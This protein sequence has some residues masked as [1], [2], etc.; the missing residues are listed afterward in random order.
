MGNE[1]RKVNLKLNENSGTLVAPHDYELDATIEYVVD[2]QGEMESQ[3][4]IM[5]AVQNLG[6]PPAL[7]DFHNWLIENGFDP[8]FPDPTNEFVS[9]YYGKKPLWKTEYSQGIVVKNCDE[10]DDDY[11]IVVECSRENKGYKYT[12]IIVTMGGCV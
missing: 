6:A 5:Q 12:Q 2:I 7:S 1:K 8:N 11:Y 9:K 3:I 10:D 4:S